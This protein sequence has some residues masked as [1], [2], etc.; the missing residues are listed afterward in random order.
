[1][2]V[3]RPENSNISH[4][5]HTITHAQQNNYSTSEAI[6][7]SCSLNGGPFLEELFPKVMKRMAL[8]KSQYETVRL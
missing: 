5:T 8:G 2:Y 1:M 4:I 7:P 6:M 3:L